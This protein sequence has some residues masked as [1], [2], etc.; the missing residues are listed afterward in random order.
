MA[1]SFQRVEFGNVDRIIIRK[2]IW[3]N[4][5]VIIVIQ[6]ECKMKNKR[7]WWTSILYMWSANSWI[8][9]PCSWVQL[10]AGMR[11]TINYI[12]SWQCNREAKRS[13]SHRTAPASLPLACAIVFLTVCTCKIINA[14]ILNFTIYS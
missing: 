7:G 12:T 6:S 3:H 9:S 4:T 13:A 11:D 2:C 10:N 1:P 5:V 14:W 8:S